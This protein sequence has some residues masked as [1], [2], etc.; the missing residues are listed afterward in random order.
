MLA[1]GAEIAIVRSLTPTVYGTIAV[2][3][4]IAL[5]LARLGQF[6]IPQGVTRF[7]SE[8]VTDTR[9]RSV[10]K[11]G[12]IIV[13]PAAVFFSLPLLLFPTRVG[14]IM[15][16]DDV[17]Q[18][19]TYFAVFVI[20]FPITRVAIAVLRARGET[21]SA[22]LSKDLLSRV[23]GLA[24]FAALAGIGI[25]QY[26][27]V[28][29]WVSLPL[30]SLVFT[31]YFI[32]RGL[33]VGEIVSVQT[34]WEAVR[35]LWSFSWPLALSSS[36]VLFLSYMDILM[37]EFFLSS[38]ATGY[39][40]SVQPLR[41]VT[42]FVLNSFTFLYMPLA[43]Q[44]F[45]NDDIESLS[46]FYKTA[47]KW[48]TTLTLPLVLV[49]SVFSVDVVR[50]FF[51]PSY[52]PAAVPL[53]VLVAGLF[54]NVLVGPNGA[55][56]KAINQPRFEM[57]SAAIGF[58]INFVLNVLLIP[59]YGIV[60]AAVATVIGYIS[61]NTIEI[62][63]IYSSIR[64]L[65]FSVNQ[66]KPLIPTVVVSLVLEQAISGTV[67]IIGLFTIGI[68]LSATHLCSVL[69]TRSLDGN[70]IKLILQ[71]EGKTGREFYHLRGILNRFS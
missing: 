29:Y 51:G 3:Y 15:N 13:T 45:S 56:A 63:L 22:V 70:D 26:G 52:I 38:S 1:L 67:G 58:V 2:G 44:Y 6:G 11:H 31:T 69:L 8:D 35:K 30:V 64:S 14:E 39:Y 59:R 60:G 25:A 68:F 4:T 24:L 62:A 53:A 61:Y 23:G 43:T 20:V 55:T 10:T 7:I 16:N 37:I 28:A 9:Q 19:L 48:I 49:F 17:A 18:Y 54:F 41:Q 33:D 27:A 12:L 32:N 21:M 47:T 71:V 57:Y 5:I 34:D 66:I 42:G 46:E 65:P 50:T 40:R 36:L